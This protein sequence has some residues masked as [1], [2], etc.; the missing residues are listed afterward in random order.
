MQLKVDVDRERLTDWFG[1]D[2]L[3]RLPEQ[4]LPAVLSHGPTR[5]LLT[6]LGLPRDGGDFLTFDSDPDLLLRPLA[7]RL[8]GPSVGAHHLLVLGEVCRDWLVLDGATGRVALAA[9]TYDQPEQVILDPLATDLS[10]L[11][12]FLHEAEQLRAT[13]ADR[14]AREGRRGPAVVDEVIG[15]LMERMRAVDPAVFD[16]SGAAPYWSA[17]LLTHGLRWAARP[18][19]SLAHEITPELMAELGEVRPVRAED[20]PAALSH[21]PT[22]RLLTAVGL[23]T[24]DYLRG[25]ETV[26]PLV[27]L[28]ESDPWYAEE[29]AEL[30]R[31]H[32]LDLLRLGDTV[33]D[34]AV[35]LDGTTGRI[36]VTAGDGD[37]DWP[38]AGLH[39]DLSAYYL[40]LWALNRLR[41]EARRWTTLHKPADWQVF[42][43]IGLLQ[44]AALQ[45]IAEID[46]TAVEDERSLWNS[47]AAD[48]HMGGLLGA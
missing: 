16:P 33:Y 5:R 26:L 25:D 48:G 45:L 44:E 42:T 24:T 20:L 2:R 36:E 32:Q 18:G 14:T 17:L 13:A 29:G 31:A 7:T 47:L 10:V 12:L 1:A 41:A 37:E 30:E 46:S 21:E 39:T 28:R 38:A 19:D 40:T 9:T 8:D 4:A 35:V 27:T 23:P 43:P 11:L 34:C 3:H 6:E 15:A 22:R